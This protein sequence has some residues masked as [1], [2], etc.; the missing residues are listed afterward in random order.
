M[1][2][3][4]EMNLEVSSMESI[5]LNNYSGRYILFK[6]SNS[7]YCGG[8]ILFKKSIVYIIRIRLCI[9]MNILVIYTK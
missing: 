9:R 7:L 1:N 4:K 3:E 6:K 2:G 8:Y 5:I